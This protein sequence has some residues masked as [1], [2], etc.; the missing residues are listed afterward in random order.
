MIEWDNASQAELMLIA[1]E[2]NACLFS[3]IGG[4]FRPELQSTVA[5]LKDNPAMSVEILAPLLASGRL[6][7][8]AADCL[9]HGRLCSLKTAQKHIAGT[10]CIPYSRR[11]VQLGHKDDATIYAIAFI[12][13]RLLLQES[14]IT[15]ENVVGA[16][17][18]LYER[19]LGHLYYFETHEICPTTLGWAFARPR[20]FCRM[21]HKEK[22]LE[23]ISPLASFSK[24]FWRAINY[25]WREIFFAHKPEYHTEL[26][27]DSEL[28]KELQWAQQRPS[29]QQCGLP[30][31]SMDDPLCFRKVLTEGEE[32]FLRSYMLKWP[33]SVYQLNQNPDTSFQSHSSGKA[34]PTIIKNCSI[35]YWANASPE[36]WISGTE[37]VCTQ[38]F[39]I[40]PEV[41]RALPAETRLCSFHTKRQERSTRHMWCQAGNSMNCLV[42]GLLNFHSSMCWKPVHVPDLLSNIRAGRLFL[43]KKSL[44]EVSLGSKGSAKGI[45]VS[46][47]AAT[48]DEMDPDY[49]NLGGKGQGQKRKCEHEL[50]LAHSS[51]PRRRMIGKQ[52]DTSAAS[53]SFALRKQL[54]LRG[55]LHPNSGQPAMNGG[56]AAF[57]LGIGGA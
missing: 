13:L 37:A 42:M 31:V 49:F 34:L 9:Y 17:F 30:A 5:D 32:L 48:D 27:I 21:R 51:L 56:G 10:S 54:L 23:E 53:L 28:E 39:P 29:S 7:R 12:G 25:T 20:M 46:D 36:R 38:G 2:T 8:S 33:D 11:G 45:G 15:L 47:A 55:R 18:S 43:W 4:F 52:E 19:F 41:T 57:R 6:M 3:D 22:V 16:D 35:M 50:E 40:H 26:C 44:E 1:K 24:L 14:D